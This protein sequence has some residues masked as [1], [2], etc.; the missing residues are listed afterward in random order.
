LDQDSIKSIAI[1]GRQPKLGIAE[2][3]SLYGAASVSH[4]SE[5]AALLSL[6]PEQ[7]DFNRLGGSLRISRVIA[8]LPSAKWNDIEKYILQKAPELAEGI[9]GKLKFGISAFG[10]NYRKQAI[11]KTALLLK[12]AIKQTGQSVRMVPHKD[13]ALGSAVVLHNGLIKQNGRELLIVS[14]GQTAYLA[15]TTNVQ[16]ID[17]YTERDRHRPFRDAKVGM[18]PPKLAQIIINL[19]VGDAKYQ[20]PQVLDPF[21]GT[22]VLLQEAMLM[23]YDIYGSDLEPRMVEY[24]IDNLTWLDGKYPDAGDYRRVE[25]G[26]ATSHQWN[27]PQNITTVA[28]ETFLGQPLSTLPNGEHLSK[29]M[30]EVN[31]LHH[32]FL[33]NLSAQIPSGTRMCLAIPTWR[34]KREFLHLS[35]LDYLTDIG[36]TRVRFKHVSDT[37]L[38]YHRDNQVVGRELL[39]LVKD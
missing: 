8:K 28:C 3:E 11:A 34:G 13:I 25:I 39:V 15:Q 10:P 38:I 32:R 35:V 22:G 24:S 23:N 20:K 6:D 14:D 31:Q 18:L 2:F 29:I 4:F 21:C 36:Y 7:I 5:H 33:A 30:H 16:D 19:G 17:S 12:K 27:Q 9:D 1:L 37:D 26:N